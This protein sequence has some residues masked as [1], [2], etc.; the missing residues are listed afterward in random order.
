MINFSEANETVVQEIVEENE[1]CIQSVNNKTALISETPN[2]VKNEN[3]IIA[4]GR[5]KS[6]LKMFR[7]CSVTTTL[8]NWY[9][10]LY[11]HMGSLAIE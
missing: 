3:L 8:K 5:G 11:S 2:V 9:F 4:S 7:I 10:C 1:T 6:T